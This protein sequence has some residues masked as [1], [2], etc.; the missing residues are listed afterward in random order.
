[1]EHD[2]I[3][4]NV[5]QDK[6]VWRLPISVNAFEDT[7]NYNFTSTYQGF[8]ASRQSS[9]HNNTNMPYRTNNRHNIIVSVSHFKLFILIHHDIK[10]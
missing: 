6:S 1:M 4:L 3:D 9:R 8:D 2:D 7:K 10:I 5:E